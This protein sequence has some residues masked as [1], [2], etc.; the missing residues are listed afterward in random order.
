[1]ERVTLFFN[2]NIS[3][4][5]IRIKTKVPYKTMFAQKQRHNGFK[6]KVSLFWEGYEYEM[7]PKFRIDPPYF[8]H[9]AHISL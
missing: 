1:M 7:S 8:K 4:N 3:E 9:T 5:K 6:Q 2:M